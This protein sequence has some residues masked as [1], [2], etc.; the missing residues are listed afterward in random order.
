MGG[1]RGESDSG[2]WWEGGEES[3]PVLAG[4]GSARAGVSPNLI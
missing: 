3:P 4:R 1:R 2:G